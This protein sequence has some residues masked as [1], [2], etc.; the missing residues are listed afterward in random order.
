MVNN[1]PCI[2]PSPVPSIKADIIGVAFPSF[3]QATRLGLGRT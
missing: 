2:A 1:S 3:F